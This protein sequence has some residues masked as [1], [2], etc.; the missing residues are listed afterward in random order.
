MTAIMLKWFDSYTGIY[1]T[2]LRT[3]NIQSVCYRS[4]NF[5][6]YFNHGELE[7]STDDSDDKA[8]SDVTQCF[9]HRS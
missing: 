8:S 1:K 9:V 2:N 3:P 5:A 6:Q 4:V 7:Y